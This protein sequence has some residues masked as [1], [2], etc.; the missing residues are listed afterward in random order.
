MGTEKWN[1]DE[2]LPVPASSEVS[3]RRDT[4]SHGGPR[5]LLGFVTILIIGWNLM[6]LHERYLQNSPTK[7]HLDPD[8]RGNLTVQQAEQLFL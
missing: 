3:S 7:G 8:S 6:A 2:Y 5:R 1:D 4:P